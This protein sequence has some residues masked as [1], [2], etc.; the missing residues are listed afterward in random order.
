[1]VTTTTTPATIPPITPLES[2]VEEEDVIVEDK[3][4]V[5]GYYLNGN[6]LMGSTVKTVGEDGMDV[7]VVGVGV[8]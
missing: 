6:F 3:M 8:T 4:A 7:V 1:M 5:E 2:F